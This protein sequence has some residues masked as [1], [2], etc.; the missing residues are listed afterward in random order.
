MARISISIS[1]RG[2]SSKSRRRPKAIGRAR[3]AAKRSSKRRAI[4]PY[5]GNYLI[6]R[7][8][9]RII[10][11]W[12][13]NSSLREEWGECL[14]KRPEL[15]NQPRTPSRALSRFPLTLSQISIGL[16]WLVIGFE[17]FFVLITPVSVINRLTQN[18]P[19]LTPNITMHR[20]MGTMQSS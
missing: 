8:F 10:A 15:S 3:S 11:N 20:S 13:T 14:P 16:R 6:D 2:P 18:P 7:R 4:A 12:Q 19:N 1:G 5:F 17:I 9:H